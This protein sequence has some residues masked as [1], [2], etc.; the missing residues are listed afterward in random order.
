MVR[1]KIKKAAIMIAL[2]FFLGSEKSTAKQQ[3]HLVP[4]LYASTASS[5]FE[6]SLVNA[7]VDPFVSFGTG[8]VLG[9]DFDKNHA[10][11]IEYEMGGSFLMVGTG[12]AGVGAFSSETASGLQL[13]ASAYYLIPIF[14]FGRARINFMGL[15]QIDPLQLGL[16]IKIPIEVSRKKPS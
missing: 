7:E 2:M 13:T 1:T 10:T 12:I 15:K 8:Y 14:I 4:G 5:G 9:H 16:M 3:T 6:V 11:Y